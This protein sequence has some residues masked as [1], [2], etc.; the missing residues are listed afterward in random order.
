[1]IFEHFFSQVPKYLAQQWAKATGRGEVGKLR[2][3][4][5][6][7]KK[8]KCISKTEQRYFSFPLIEE[9]SMYVDIIIIFSNYNDENIFLNRGYILF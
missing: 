8:I 1:M 9:S 5:Y 2:I 7:E 3:I 6:V 4:K